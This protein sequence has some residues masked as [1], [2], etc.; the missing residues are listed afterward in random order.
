[1]AKPISPASMPTPFSNYNHAMLVP[2]GSQL[3]V[4]SGQLGIR[5]DGTIPA[6]TAEQTRLC[7]ASVKALL[8]EAGMDLGDVVRIN[9][10]VTA[11]EHME[12]YMS[13]RNE[14]FPAPYPASTLMIVSGFTKPEFHVEVEILAARE[15]DG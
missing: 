8:E 1:M 11:R 10:Y 13:V 7:F 15:T 2:E 5:A 12:P 4:S 9:A 3:L 14:L 6:D